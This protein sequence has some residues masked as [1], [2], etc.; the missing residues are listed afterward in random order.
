MDGRLLGM[1]VGEGPDA[2]EQ[3][4]PVA[5]RQIR[6]TDGALEEDVA[7]EQRPL[8]RD[9]VGDVTRAVPWREHDVDLESGKGQVLAAGDGHIGVV[10]LERPKS[11]PG[12]VG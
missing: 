4:P 6:A 5:T 9:R 7:G 12:D 8:V 1:A 2:L 10:A 3:G 11:R